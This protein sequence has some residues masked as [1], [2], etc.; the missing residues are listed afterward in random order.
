M[1]SPSI[2]A[3]EDLKVLAKGVQAVVVLTPASASSDDATP[4]ERAAARAVLKLVLGPENGY[5]ASLRPH[6]PVKEV[7]ALRKA[8]HPN[9]IK[10]LGY[11]YD[12]AAWEHIIKL[13][14]QAVRLNDV[15]AKA[16][17]ADERAAKAGTQPPQAQVSL[18]LFVRTAQG[19]LA[20][21]AHLHSIGIAHRDVKPGNIMLS[22]TG[23]PVLKDFGTAWDEAAAGDDVEPET[24]ERRGKSKRMTTSVGTGAYRAPELLF[25]PNEYDAKALDLWA[26]GAT[27]AEFFRQ[28]GPYPVEEYSGP[29]S[30][31]E[32]VGEALAA[33]AS[34]KIGRRPSPADTERTP[35]FNAQ[36][37]DLGLAAS[38][39]RVLG[40]PTKESWP[41]FDSL[42]D[43]GKMFFEERAPV[44]LASMLPGLEDLEADVSGPILG[45]LEGLVRLEA[46]RRTNAADA[47]ALLDTDVLRPLAQDKA[48]VAYLDSL[49]DPEA[50]KFV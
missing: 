2:M 33:V 26:A 8:N 32:D 39:F 22:W 46:K 11:S 43:A 23:E 37:G 30:S 38:I 12:K 14:L 40:T 27:L 3:R 47:L 15:L 29:D 13:P 28:I 1:A 34:L 35:L 36:F 24:G 44:P 49:I 41:S 16:F 21:L 6:N 10:L 48:A 19:L 4:R 50:V 7:A 20:A 25:G 18:P 42:P 5:A 45:L 17:V 31:D 9:I